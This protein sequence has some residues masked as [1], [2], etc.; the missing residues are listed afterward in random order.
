MIFFKSSEK[1]KVLKGVYIAVH[2]QNKDY[3][4]FW[5]IFKRIFIFGQTYDFLKSL[6]KLKVLIT[7]QKFYVRLSVF[8]SYTYIPSHHSLANFN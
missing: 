4:H 7:F 1:L 8:T 3:G 2:V 6:E 5:K